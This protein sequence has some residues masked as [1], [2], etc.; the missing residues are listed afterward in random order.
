MDPEQMSSTTLMYKEIREIP[1]AT[2]S[3]LTDGRAQIRAVA[4]KLREADPNL[5]VTVARGSSDHAATFFKYACELKL[6]IPVASVGPSIASIYNARLKLSNAVCIGISQSGQSPDIVKMA[7][8]AGDHGAVS[9]AIT[10]VPTS[11]LANVCDHL[12]DIHAGLE[13]SVA[14]TKTFVTSVVAELALL[15]HWAE[16]QQLIDALDAL[17][18]EFERAVECDWPELRKALRGHDSLIVLGRG[19]S[20]AISHEAALKFKETCQIHAESYSSAEVLHGPVSVVADGYPV[21]ALVARDASEASITS[22]CDQLAQRGA[23]VFVT[24]DKAEYASSLA[25]AKTSHPLTDPLALVVSFY[26]FIERM[27]KDRGINPDKP[28]HLSKVTETI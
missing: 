21:L 17:P 19:P 4:A 26:A 20:L 2:R 9:I 18:D 25:F 6:G 11:P 14:A 24:S 1:A 27:A 23:K 13:K 16:D 5:V 15:A 7:Q 22:V 28:R 10:N 12:I 3:L 8:S